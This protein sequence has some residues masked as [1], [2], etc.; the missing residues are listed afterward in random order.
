[1]SG[2]LRVPCRVH[3]RH[4]QPVSCREVLPGRVR[5]LHGLPCRHVWLN[6]GNGVHD[7][8]GTVPGRVLLSLGNQCS[9]RLPCRPVLKRCHVCLHCLPSRHLWQCPVTNQQC[10]QWTVPTWEIW[11]HV[12]EHEPDVCSGLLGGL[13]MPCRQH[14]GPA[15][16]NQVL[17]GHVLHRGP[18]ELH[19]LPC[20]AL[21]S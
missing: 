7:L 12:G 1:M 21:L 6:H 8:H 11:R 13:R 2:R 15:R 17:E 16:C 20:R 4:C 3:H 5:V 10:V 9:Q 14:H 18:W 19:H